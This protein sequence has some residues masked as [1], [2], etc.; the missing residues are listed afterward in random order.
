MRALF[1][2]AS[3]LALALPVPAAAQDPCAD[4]VPQARPQNASRDVVGQELDAIVEQGFMTFAVYEDNPPYSWQE[5]GT[6]RGVDVEVARLVAADIGVEPRFRFVGAGENLDADL[7]DNVWMG[8]VIGG[9]VSNVM[10]RVPYDSRLACR[11]EQ[12]VFT[13]IYARESIA[14]A[15]DEAA[16]PDEPPVPAYFRFDTVAVE[17]DSISDFYLS[18][19]PGGGTADQVR[20][21]PD[22]TAAM[23]ALAAGETKAAMGPL[24]QLEHGLVEGLAVHTPPLP[25]FSV[26]TWSLGVAV[27]FRYRPLAY[28]V[29]D[30]IAAAVSDGRIEA[31][32]ADLGLTWQA[33]EW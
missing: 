18:S 4:H 13:G 14:I 19:L 21:Y 22:M 27:N 20:R 32:H 30:A 23:A 3:C 2:A 5:G 33:P 10:M 17:N 12:V 6:P 25:A 31:I 16:Y 28:A 24:S 29:D 7:R 1:A 11:A 9:Q 15:Y 8:P 26:G